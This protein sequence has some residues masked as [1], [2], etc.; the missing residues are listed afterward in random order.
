VKRLILLTMLWLP[1][2]V[3]FAQDSHADTDSAIGLPSIFDG[4]VRFRYVV[5]GD[6]A[7]SERLNAAAADQIVI[8][9]G[10]PTDIS[11]AVPDGA[12][13]ELVSDAGFVPEPLPG[14]GAMYGD[15]W[16]VAIDGDGQ[17][18]L[19]NGDH[20][21]DDV[22][23][24]IRS[25]FYA[26]LLTNV[27]VAVA[28]VNVDAIN[29]PRILL[30]PADGASSIT[31][32]LYAGPIEHTTL[33][34]ADP[35]LSKLL[36]AAL[37]DW[38]RW[39]CFGMA[40]LFT[41]INGVVGNVGMSII[42][43]SLTVKV[44]MTPL[45]KAAD[46]LQQSVNTTAALLQPE[47]AA[48]KRDFKGEEA[49]NRVLATYKKHD[50]HPLYT[51]KSL[52]GFLLQI[53][54]FIAAFDMLGDSFAL[55]QTSFLWMSDLS[56]PDQWLALPVTLPFFGGH[57]NLLPCLMTAFTLLTSWLQKDAA[58]TPDLARA[59]RTRLFWMAGAFFL[60]FYTFPAGMVL[61]WTTN[62]VLALLKLTPKLL[63]DRSRQH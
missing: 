54:I 34:A 5:P 47:L 14:F 17:H 21:T 1:G 40:W 15:V 4:A 38:L 36:Y 62:N 35:V 41:T 28:T 30:L 6:T 56:K 53:P 50:V 23:L 18:S 11:I 19:E 12:A 2:T 16:P 31:F 52:A 60:L 27:S 48:I 22:W 10:K 33:R 9:D 7:A 58:L 43:L 37:W 45:T 8:A 13:V 61:Y 55:H 63:A 57:L 3:L 49:H 20:S 59:Q 51:M 26:V 32:R 46:R 42:V 24:G 39:L 29:E 25:R 44:L